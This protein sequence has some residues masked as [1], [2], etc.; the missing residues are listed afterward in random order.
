MTFDIHNNEL[1]DTGKN[2]S[3][4][5]WVNS[6][7][8]LYVYNVEISQ[9]LTPSFHKVYKAN[10]LIYNDLIFKIDYIL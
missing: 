6:H 4:S 3:G 2:W 1:S 7:L 5:A 9:S 10:P 8:Y